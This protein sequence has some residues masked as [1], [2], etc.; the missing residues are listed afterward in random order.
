MKYVRPIHEFIKQHKLASKG[1][2]L[3]PHPLAQALSMEAEK[4]GYG[5]GGRVRHSRKGHGEIEEG[6]EGGAIL[7]KDD[8]ISRIKEL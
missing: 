4:Y 6:C 3:I 5:E 8:L 2:K 1:L 7:T